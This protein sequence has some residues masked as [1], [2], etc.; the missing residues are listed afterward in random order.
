M[1]THRGIEDILKNTEKPFSVIE[2]FDALSPKRKMLLCDQLFSEDQ[3][4][5]RNTTRMLW[6]EATQSD[7]KKLGH[8]IRILRFIAQT[9]H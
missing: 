8:F 7:M 1:Y 9:A 2:E 4:V 6:P 5:F 3:N